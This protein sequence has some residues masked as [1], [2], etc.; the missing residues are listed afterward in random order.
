MSIRRKAR[1][2]K[3]TGFAPAA[4][5]AILT[6]NGSRLPRSGPELLSM[7]LASHVHPARS[8]VLSALFALAAASAMA[9]Q[10]VLRQAVGPGKFYSADPAA[11]QQEVAHWVG[12]AHPLPSTGKLR[13]IIAP[14][15]HYKYSGATLG[16]AFAPLQPGQFDRVIVIAPSHFSRFEGCSIPQ[17]DAFVTPLGVVPIDWRAV[18]HLNLSTL[19]TVKQLRYG[20]ASGRERTHEA[21]HSIEAVLPFLQAR[22]GK[23][24]LVPIL[25]GE[26]QDATGKYSQ[27]AIEAVADR[28]RTLL[29]ER[30]LLVVSTDFTHFGNKYRFAP[31]GENVDEQIRAL[32]RGAF[33]TLVNLDAAALDQYRIETGN[34]ICGMMALQLLISVLPD[35]VLG[36]LASH[37]LSAEINHDY[38]QCVS[39]AAMHFYDYGHRVRSEAPPPELAPENAKPK[40]DKPVVLMTNKASGAGTEGPGTPTGPVRLVVQ[41]DAPAA[42]AAPAQRPAGPMTLNNAAIAAAAATVRTES[43]A[44]PPVPPAP[45]PVV[46]E[47]P[48]AA[49]PGNTV[50]ALPP[51]QPGGARTLTNRQPIPVESTPTPEAADAP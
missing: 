40:S 36:T 9:A 25:A 39:F 42:A 31:F 6:R 16:E 4:G 37:H 17:A 43:P 27:P 24:T 41:G 5:C 20:K 28:L 3:K 51:E 18:E 47:A 35:R 19:V 22:L 7:P 38:G 1:T 14:H 23:F 29:D 8:V 21:E 15:S 2:H 30:T 33:E 50:V 48:P 44:P 46:I 26:F 10:P 11:L 45:A 12:A 34:P 32:D 13:A 49:I